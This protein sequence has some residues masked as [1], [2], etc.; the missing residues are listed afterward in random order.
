LKESILESENDYSRAKWSDFLREVPC[1][2]CNGAR[3]KPEV[4]AVKVAAKSIA[5]VTALSLG[6]TVKFFKDISLDKRDV[7]I[8]AQVLREIKSRLDFLNLGWT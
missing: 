3:L 1:P 4:L 5:D 7:K 6:E 8:A 2:A